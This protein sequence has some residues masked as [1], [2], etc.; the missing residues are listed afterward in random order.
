MTTIERLSVAES[1]LTTAQ[2][3]LKAAAFPDERILRRESV[4]ETEQRI[5]ALRQQ[6]DAEMQAQQ[7]RDAAEQ[8]ARKQLDA[9]AKE[10]EASRRALAEAV[11]QVRSALDAVH[12]RAEAHGALIE[13]WR[14]ELIALGLTGEIRPDGSPQSAAAPHQAV[15]IDG[16]RWTHFAPAQVVAFAVARGVATDKTL[17]DRLRGVVGPNEWR[18]AETLTVTRRTRKDVR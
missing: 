15:V 18:L 1:A 12:Q 4:D 10:L 3:R 14:G 11:A 16:T 6:L 5:A 2:G 13:H 8:A 7:V 17:S 9:G